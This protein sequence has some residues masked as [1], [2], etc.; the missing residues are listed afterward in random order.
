VVIVGSGAAGISAAGAAA[1]EGAKVLVLEKAPEPFG[2]G[3][4]AHFFIFSGGGPDWVRAPGKDGGTLGDLWTDPMLKNTWIGIAGEIANRL[5]DKMGMKWV[6]MPNSPVLEKS[7]SRL[8][9]MFL[10]PVATDTTEYPL[11][12][13]G[14][15]SRLDATI[16]NPYNR[17]MV[18]MITMKRYAEKLGAELLTSTP[19]EA[20]V[21][22]GNKVTGVK[23]RDANGR[24]FYIQATK[25][26]ILAAGC[27]AGSVPMLKRYDPYVGGRS[28]AYNGATVNMGDGIRMGLG[29]GGVLAGT[30]DIFSCMDGGVTCFERGVGPWRQYLYQAVVQMS[31]WPTLMVDKY[32]RRWHNE[33][34]GWDSVL[35][36]LGMLG[37]PD[38]LTYT[39]FDR[40][41]LEAFANAAKP[42]YC[43]RPVQKIDYHIQPD[44]S[45]FPL[46]PV[47]WD[48]IK[49][50]VAARK[51]RMADS[52]KDLANI[53]G[54]DPSGLQTTIERYNHI[55]YNRK[56]TDFYKSPEILFPI[57]SPP[58]YIIETRPTLFGH[59][60][61]LKINPM[62]QAVTDSGS[63]IGG[64]YIAGENANYTANATSA[65]L[66]WVAGKNATGKGIV[67]AG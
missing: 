17:N 25:G 54:V 55:C 46:T 53:Y 24:P 41:H 60:A 21:T 13:G 28:G 48:G 45:T 22:D 63:P 9:L 16:G 40:G 37:L 8:P 6:Y 33:D 7:P 56:D 43:E 36:S 15:A 23:A 34:T 66:G 12:P 27:M 31:R 3:G 65:A 10:Y 58:Y 47:F 4:M 42:V 14:M 1:E 11:A 20:L 32:G 19:V 44:G 49:Q 52:V 5:T 30:N 61:G 50:A 2:T 64:L 59:M 39:I 29:V 35:T 38:G 18:Y 26:V 57:D 62:V 67:L 51:M